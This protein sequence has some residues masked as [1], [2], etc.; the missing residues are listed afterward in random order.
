MAILAYI[1]ADHGHAIATARVFPDECC[2]RQARSAAIGREM[3]RAPG[4]STGPVSRA[5]IVGLMFCA[6]PPRTT[7]LRN[8]RPA[9]PA[10][11][12]P[13]LRAP[14]PIGHSALCQGGTSAFCRRLRSPW[15]GRLPCLRDDADRLH[16]SLRSHRSAYN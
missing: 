8:G 1:E 5:S 6:T 13:V 16:L 2:A 12:P 9:S 11:A 3:H 14:L 10:S 15:G 7:M 4:P